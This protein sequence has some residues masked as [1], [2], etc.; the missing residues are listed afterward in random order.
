MP[1]RGRSSP[2]IPTGSMFY[3]DYFS[4][5]IFG[6]DIARSS[7]PPYLCW[8]Y[9]DRLKERGMDNQCRYFV[10]D[11][12]GCGRINSLNAYLL[13]GPGVPGPTHIQSQHRT[14]EGRQAGLNLLLR[15]VLRD[16]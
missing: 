1:P 2:S 3:Y 11:R 9:R 8:P 6:F 10:K 16:D 14:V 4:M 15:Q 7:P 12:C 5:Y 13:N